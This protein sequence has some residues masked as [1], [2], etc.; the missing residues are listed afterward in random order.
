LEQIAARP[1]PRNRL[2]PM[3]FVVAFGVVSLLADP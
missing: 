2:T 1:Q 3:R